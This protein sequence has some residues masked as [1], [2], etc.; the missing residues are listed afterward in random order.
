MNNAALT[1]CSMQAFGGEGCERHSHGCKTLP[2]IS[3]FH[4]LLDTSEL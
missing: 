3:I 4:V 2:V 1:A